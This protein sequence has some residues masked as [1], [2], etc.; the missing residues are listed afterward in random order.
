MESRRQEV[1]DARVIE[2]GVQQRLKSIR[3]QEESVRTRLEEL[4]QV[5]QQRQK[6]IE[7]Y[8]Q[9]MDTCRQAITEAENKIRSLAGN[10]SSN[11]KPNSG[12]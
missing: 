10:R 7:S 5:S 2:A 4:R 11:W 6:D 12:V 8:R 9:K 3:E 1:S